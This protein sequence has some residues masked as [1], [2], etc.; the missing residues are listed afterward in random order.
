MKQKFSNIIKGIMVTAACTILSFNQQASAQTK[1]TTKMKK[2]LFVVTSHDKKG[3]TEHATGYYLS[4][5][6]HAWE[7]LHWL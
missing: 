1:N 7:V 3:S 6:S 5:V 2:V 4:E